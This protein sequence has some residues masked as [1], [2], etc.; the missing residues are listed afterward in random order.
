MHLAVIPIF[1]NAGA[2]ILPAIIAPLATAFALL[3]KPRELLAAC[4]RR[5]AVVGLVLVILAGIWLL[6]STVRARSAAARQT[7]RSS[8]TP[9]RIDWV[10]IA[11]DRIRNQALGTSTRPTS[12]PTSSAAAAPLVFRTAYSRTGH[13]GSPSPTNLKLLWSYPGP[14]GAPWT[15]LSSP[16]VSGNRVYAAAMLQDV[17]G[18]L[19]LI[20]CLD[21][22]TGQ[23]LWALEQIDNKPLRGIF[24]S[25]ALTQ[26]GKFLIIGQGLHE[27]ADCELLC[28]YAST[29]QL[30]WKHKT[31]LHIE[32]S[33]AIHGDT[34]IAGA[35]AIEGA[36][37]RPTSHPGFAFA[38]RISTGQF[39][40]QRDIPDPECA[41]AVT[42]DGRVLIGAG[43][44][45][46]ALHALT[47][48]GAPL[49]HIP[50]PYP[51]TSAVTL[52][53]DLAI[54]GAGDK[55]LIDDSLTSSGAVLAADLSTGQIRWQFDT[56]S[57]ILGPIAATPDKLIIPLR[58]GQVLA[59]D[60]SGKPLWRQTLGKSLLLAG[61]AVSTTHIYIPTRD[62]QLFILDLPTG[63][64]LEK[65]PLNDPANPGDAKYTLSSP[66]L[67]HGR[68]YLGSETGGL[69]CY[70][71]TTP[72]P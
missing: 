15:F 64:I 24:S 61:P 56:Q 51:L 29:G 55:D 41:P 38:L 36:D 22:N 62:G 45:G 42:P 58:D 63:Q 50:S 60:H 54:I 8:T 31:P 5:P 48:D 52:T 17:G 19:G 35:G 40:W 57:A 27:D 12:L 2:A 39:L 18:I 53:Q 3:L 71:G 66:A 13:D 43:F 6:V 10:R 49:W 9:Q 20:A 46:N 44:N 33:P 16:L 47:S 70:I 26:D 11:R 34:V 23:P 67:A 37:R 1:V 65:H 14:G 7:I 4:R 68:L 28:L 72:P 59:L 32:S 21:A 25:P 69:R 30:H